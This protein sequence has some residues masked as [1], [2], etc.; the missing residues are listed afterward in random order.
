MVCGD[1]LTPMNFNRNLGLLCNK[2]YHKFQT[3]VNQTYQ[4]PIQQSFGLFLLFFS[5]TGLG[6]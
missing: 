1:T 5:S 2:C 4:P 6:F 3:Q